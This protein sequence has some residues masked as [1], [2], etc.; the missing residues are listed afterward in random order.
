M[1]AP[2]LTSLTASMTA[3]S[4]DARPMQRR[5]VRQGRDVSGILLLDKPTGIT[6]NTALQRAK[7][8]FQAR[9]AGH[10]GSLDPL[11]SGMLPLCFGQATKVSG[12]LLES[13][14][15]YEVE[16]VI[17]TQTD[18]A[19]ADGTV[20]NT[21]ENDAI[22]EAGLMAAIAHHIGPI[23]QVPPMYSA[24]KHKGRRLHEL[25]RQGIEV[26]R[27]PRTVQIRSIDLLHF[28]PHRP[29]LRV[30]CSKGT[31]IR[32]LIETLAESM[33]TLAH[34]GMLR[35]E[36]VEPF[37]DQP[38][39]TLDALE[40]MADD[41]AAMDRLLLGADAALARF[42]A[43]TLD[44]NASAALRHGRPVQQAQQGLEAPES[45]YCGVVRAYD[46]SGEFMGVADL[47]QDGRVVAKRLFVA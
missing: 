25:A 42:P 2:N 4:V 33:S 34:V 43:L 31:Y 3:S 14:K 35:R 37:V 18:T 36:L 7:R 13:D 40:G 1:L 26:D 30:H 46:S 45:D 41:I 12:M 15:V 5:R 47:L 16:A 20:I 29:R 6:S 10:T 11:A 38:M 17:G 22:T 24:L 28:D 9:K 8:C 21:A 19:D 39:V 27:P 44:A 23:Q 32:T